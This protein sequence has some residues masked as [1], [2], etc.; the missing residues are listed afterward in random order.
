[1]TDLS[2]QRRMAADLL[3]IGQNRVYI[4][5]LHNDEV[6]EAVT[7]ADIRSLIRKGLIETR[8]IIGTSRVRARK[9]KEQKDS[10][11]RSGPGSR[12]G[13]KGARNPRKRAWIRMIRP[14]RAKLSE[15][16]ASK[17]ITPAQ[18]RVYYLK[19][20]GGAF[21]SKAHLVSHLK[22]DGVL[23]EE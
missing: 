20:K 4:N 22:T 5:P 9:L 7:R 3:K 13:A 23:T 6:A 2:N 1:M 12:K 14:V 11:R 15:L 16:R 10:G 19:A 18:Y 21:R 17:K 8:S